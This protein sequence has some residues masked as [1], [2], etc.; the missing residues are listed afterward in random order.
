MIVQTYKDHFNKI[1]D[2][3]NV[4]HTEKD[5]FSIASSI[6]S[7]KNT[8]RNSS[9]YGGITTES[10]S[11][12]V[13]GALIWMSRYKLIEF[14][15]RQVDSKGKIISDRVGLSDWTSCL[16]LYY[17]LFVRWINDWFKEI[18]SG[19]IFTSTNRLSLLWGNGLEILIS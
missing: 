4:H 10:E 14:P 6:S 19:K 12:E 16:K 18:I 1:L 15:Y 7:T 11:N 9:L 8:L 2:K 3:I 13:S 17:D 5:A